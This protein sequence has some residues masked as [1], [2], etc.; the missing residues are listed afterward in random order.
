MV[1]GLM[2]TYTW[3]A[4]M[5]PLLGITALTMIT[6]ANAFMQLNTDE[7]M[8]GRVVAL[9]MM[10]FIGGTPLGA[11]LVGWIGEQYG[12]RWTLL[13]GGLMTVLGVSLASLLFARRHL[14]A[15]T[16]R[17]HEAMSDA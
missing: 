6:S 2:P 10:I 14:G 8:R 3:F 9:Y 5:T 13:F 15:R 12:A 1:A 16:P 17:A 11:P 7:G 4:L